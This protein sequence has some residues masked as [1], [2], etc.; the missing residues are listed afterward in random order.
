M[1]TQKLRRSHQCVNTLVIDELG[2]AHGKNRIDVAVFNGCIH[3]YE[4]KSSKDTLERFPDQLEIYRKCLEK[5][6]LVVAPNHL[7]EMLAM[8]PSW[9]G[10]VLAE[11]GVRGG[12]RFST[13]QRARKN[14]EIDAVSLAHLLWKNEAVAL[15][16]HLGVAGNQ[17]C[18]SRIE[19]YKQ[20][21][22]L[23]SIRELSA[24]IKEQITK[25]EAWRVGQ[26]LS[27]NGGLPRLASK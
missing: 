16:E 6:T 10:I 13:I 21:S 22:R 27:S 18:K 14:P 5:L 24:W 26:R 9:C 19:L 25:R 4:I 3:G 23:I 7:D 12:I 1:H 15:L 11:K 20:L 17:H 8:A 2:L